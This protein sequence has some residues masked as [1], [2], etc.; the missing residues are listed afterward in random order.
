MPSLKLN[1][2]NKEEKTRAENR[3][4][5]YFKVTKGAEKGKVQEKPRRFC[6]QLL[7]MKK[8]IEIT[9]DEYDKAL[10][11]AAKAEAK[12]DKTNIRQVNAKL[13]KLEDENKKLKEEKS[14]LERT[15]KELKE[16]VET[17]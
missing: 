7:A 5:V 9:K 14:V 4:I 6:R 8:A 2:M 11:E 1:I 13:K 16:Q 3:E 15:T 10:E 12:A 17:K